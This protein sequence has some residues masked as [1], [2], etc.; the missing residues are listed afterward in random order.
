MA[1]QISFSDEEHQIIHFVT[2]YVP[3]GRLGFLLIL[4]NRHTVKRRLVHYR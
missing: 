4:Y 3:S 2:S 1:L